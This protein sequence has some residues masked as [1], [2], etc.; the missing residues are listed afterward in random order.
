M[1]T[2][3][4]AESANDGFPNL[5][6][7]PTIV[8]LVGLPT[9]Y[10][11][12]RSAYLD[13]LTQEAIRQGLPPAV[14]DAVAQV[15]TAYNPNAIGGVGEVGLMQV[16][17]QTAAMLGYRGTDADLAEPT[18]NVR[19][20]VAYLARAWRLAGG[21]LCRALMK[22]RAGHGEERMT[23][24]SVEYCRRARAHLAL[25]GSPLAGEIAPPTEPGPTSASA[26]AA[27]PRKPSPSSLPQAASVEPHRPRETTK[28]TRS[29]ADAGAGNSS[30]PAERR[31]AQARI[32]LPPSRPPTVKLASVSIGADV[33]TA[34]QTALQLK[35][36]EQTRRI[37]AERDARLKAIDAKL[38]RSGLI[39]ATGI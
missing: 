12:G 34:A 5:P 35:K 16:R 29:I 9:I 7:P 22:Y 25:I 15:E 37:W 18:T 23:P 33:L 17:P 39:I 21:D 4:Q 31:S 19:Y 24:L 32:V 1:A 2:S 11:K 8:G 13:M 38:K 26:A 6:L 27:Q 20:G 36:Q 14:A 10:N 3:A 30:R 28:A